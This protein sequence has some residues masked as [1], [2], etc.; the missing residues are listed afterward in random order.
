[1]ALD[2]LD[3]SLIMLASDS[4]VQLNKRAYI[5]Y[6]IYSLRLDRLLILLSSA[7]LQG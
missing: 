2:I 6:Q 5:S 3:H 7:S 1:M 4:A